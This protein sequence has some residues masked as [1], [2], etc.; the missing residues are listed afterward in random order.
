MWIELIICIALAIPD[1]V[2][3]GAIPVV[4]DVWDIIVIFILSILFWNFSVGIMLIEFL[5]VVVLDFVPFEVAPWFYKY[6]R[7]KKGKK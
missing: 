3:V 7:K 6:V 2:V 4:G 1:M 5:P